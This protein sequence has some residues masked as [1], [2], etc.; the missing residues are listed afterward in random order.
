MLPKHVRN[1]FAGSLPMGLEE[2][3][4]WDS[5][6]CHTS[7]P[8]A[9]ENP[10]LLVSRFLLW[11]PAPAMAQPLQNCWPKQVPG[12]TAYGI[13]RARTRSRGHSTP[14]IKDYFR[15][16]RREGLM[17]TQQQKLEW[18][19]ERR[20]PRRCRASARQHS[21]YDSPVRICVLSGRRRRSRSSTPEQASFV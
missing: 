4:N 18:H 2:K 3:P 11:I 9:S 10:C 21:S 8:G 15:L 19:S 13:G 17:S 20:G 16:I 1:S 14:D 6:L 12:D 7:K 5:T